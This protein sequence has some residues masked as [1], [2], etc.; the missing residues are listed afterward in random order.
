MIRLC[1]PACSCTLFGCDL[2]IEEHRPP[3]K[4]YAVTSKIFMGQAK[5]QACFQQ[6]ACGSLVHT[7][8]R[9]GSLFNK[10]PAFNF[11]T[12]PPPQHF[13]KAFIL[14]THS[15]GPSLH[16][17]KTQR[18][19]P[20][21]ALHATLHCTPFAAL[22]TTTAGAAL[23]LHCTRLQQGLHGGGS[24]HAGARLHGDDSLSADNFLFLHGRWFSSRSSPLVAFYLCTTQTPAQ[25]ALLTIVASTS[26]TAVS[27]QWLS[28]TSATGLH[29]LRTPAQPS[30]S[31]CAWV[32]RMVLLSARTPPPQTLLIQAFAYVPIPTNLRLPHV[33]S[34][35]ICKLFSEQAALLVASFTTAQLAP[36]GQS[37]WLLHKLAKTLGSFTNYTQLLSGGLNLHL[38]W[39]RPPRLATA[40]RPPPL[41]RLSCAV[42]EPPLHRL[43]LARAPPQQTT[44]PASSTSLHYAGSTSFSSLSEVVTPAIFLLHAESDDSLPMDASYL[45]LHGISNRALSISKI[46]LHG[47]STNSGL[48]DNLSG[49]GRGLLHE[50]LHAALLVTA[51]TAQSLHE[52]ST[53][54]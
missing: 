21:F 15:L 37:S 38:H 44:A 42:N 18:A 24:L 7:L 32:S 5:G 51:S 6:P 35:L 23:F 22:H 9:N 53:Q 49:D 1:I 12:L 52:A 34:T 20:F 45:P 13:S 43:S 28:S 40:P 46:L 31:F 33:S 8:F 50:M 47:G 41:H 27:S 3:A 14:G 36:T 19:W 25:A 4:K 17:H 39:L 10:L 48:G 54:E 16:E 29:Q 26:V 11:S 2:S 30:R